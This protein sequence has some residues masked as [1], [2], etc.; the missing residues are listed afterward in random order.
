LIKTMLTCVRNQGVYI[1]NEMRTY[2][3]ECPRKQGSWGQKKIKMGKKRE[4]KQ[5]DIYK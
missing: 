4:K 1:C 5:I 2:E 3:M